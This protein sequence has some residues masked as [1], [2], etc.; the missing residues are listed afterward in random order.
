MDRSSSEL[1]FTEG[2]QMVESTLIRLAEVFSQVT[3]PRK[4]RGVRHPFQGMVTLVFLGLLA[5]IT[6]MAV[7]V[8]WATA[9]WGELREPLGFTREQP[10][11]DTTISRSLAKL[12]LAEFRQAFSLWLKSALADHQTLWVAA[13]DGKT[14]CQGLAADG[15]PVHMLNVFLQQ[16]KVTLDQ[17][18]VNGDKTN[19]PGSL[20]R[21]LGELLSAYP[22]L[23]L[24]TGD[25]IFAQR[26]LLELLKASGCDYLFQV[27]ANQPDVLDALRTCFAQAS[28]ARPASEMTEKRGTTPK[29][30][31]YGSTSTTPS[32]F[33]SI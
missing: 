17:W 32:T 31:G 19:E 18:S 16:T 30:A 25:A 2:G 26:P 20:Q 11:C 14:C 9:H 13:I 33:V 6:E 7:L 5:R 27:K 22:A 1:G 21:H 10:P 23:G 8:R 24:L 28:Q 29:P 12:S 15:S 4:P 3:D